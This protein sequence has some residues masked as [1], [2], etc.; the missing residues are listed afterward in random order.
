[1]KIFV[2][3]SLEIHLLYYCHNV[4]ESSYSYKYT[5]AHFSI[6]SQWHDNFEW[7]YINHSHLYTWKR[8]IFCPHRAPASIYARHRV[9]LVRIFT[10][11]V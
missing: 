2:N 3:N 8:R 4:R 1:M 5:A 9:S 7:L 10:R 6:L 11:S